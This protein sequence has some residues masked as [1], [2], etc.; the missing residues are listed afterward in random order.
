LPYNRPRG[1]YP[2]RDGQTNRCYH[3]F[4]RVALWPELDD[5]DEGV[6]DGVGV[7]TIGIDEGV[8]VGIG[9]GVGDIV[10]VQPAT[11]REAT[12]SKRTIIAAIGLNCILTPVFRVEFKR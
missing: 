11:E 9:V 5:G 3:F 1:S 8:E 7:V 12:T 2:S 10:V 4:Q 6:D